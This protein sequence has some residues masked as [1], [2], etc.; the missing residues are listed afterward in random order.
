MSAL[1][2]LDFSAKSTLFNA[3]ADNTNFVFKVEGPIN[4]EVMNE[5]NNI[6]SIRNKTNKITGEKE[7]QE[8]VAIG[9]R[10]RFLKSLG[11]DLKFEKMC[12]ENA[13]RN[14]VLSG[15]AELPT[16]LAFMLKTYYFDGEGKVENSS[17]IYALNNAIEENVAGY[18]FGNIESMY[19]RKISTLLYDMFTGMRL[20]SAWDG[21]SSVNGGYIIAKNN[22]DVLAYH[23][24]MADEFKDF[25]I[26]HLPSKQRVARSNRAGR[27][28]LRGL[29]PLF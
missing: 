19:Y 17:L 26:E 28:F 20:S 5:F 24:C 22:G 4:D 7:A 11:C 9:D 29:S 23:S 16:V 10:M 6:Y 1:N 25:W 14:L 3:S 12:V 18:S 27:K 2:V 8:E 15:G 21:R 13:E